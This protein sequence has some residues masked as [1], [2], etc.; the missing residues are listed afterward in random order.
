MNEFDIDKAYISQYDKLLRKF[1]REHELSESQL[2]EINK[3]KRIN[4]LRD[5]A[6]TVDTK[7]STEWEQF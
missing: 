4:A 6:T 7:D 3:Y 5:D 2:Q 1:D